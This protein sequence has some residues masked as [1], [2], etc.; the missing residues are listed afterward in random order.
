VGSKV[1][2][3]P[4]ILVIGG[5]VMGANHARTVALSTSAE[6]VGV[7]DPVEANGSAVALRT[8]SAWFSSVPAPSIFDAAIVA[9]P[10]D[11]HFEV[12]QT[13][14]GDGVPLLVEKPVTDSLE[15]T[16]RLISISR[17]RGTVLMCGFVERFNPAIVTARTIVSSPIHLSAIRHSPYVPRIRSGV[18]WDLLVH[19]VDLVLGFMGSTQVSKV[20]SVRSSFHAQSGSESEDVVEALLTFDNGGIAHA[21]ASRLGHKKIRTMSITEPDRL[22]EIDL[23]RRDITVFR[24]VS[25]QFTGSEAPGYRQQTIIDI[26][27]IANN[28][29]PL[30]AQFDHFLGL[31][32]G[33]LDRDYE[34][35]TIFPAHSIISQVVSGK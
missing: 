13:L 18:A 28:R 1:L 32:N 23:L 16:S 6:L 21:S 31:I 5:G 2:A 25:E 30:A 24:H 22:V 8:G 7:V 19:D 3:V 9:T 20:T 14:I 12:A 15:T 4:R 27:E 11:F 29:E 10:T 34:R 33:E 35:T 26:P 17:E